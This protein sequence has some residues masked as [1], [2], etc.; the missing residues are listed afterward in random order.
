MN[1]L[2]VGNGGREH[3]IAWKVRQS[4]Q[5]KTVFVAPGNAGT[6]IEPGIQNIDIQPS[7]IDNLIAFAQNEQIDLVIIGPEAALAAGIVDAFDRA[8]IPCFGPTRRAAQLEAS[9]HYA[10]AFLERY[11]IPT[12][13]YRSFTDYGQS[14]DYISTKNFPIVIKA[15]GLAAGKGVVIAQNREE[16]ITALQEMLLQERFGA[17]G[18]RVVIE[19]FLIGEEASFICVVDG[20]QVIPL[21]TSQDHKARDDG[22]QGPNTGGMGAYSPAPLITETCHQRIMQ[23]IIHP[24]LK[25]L[26]NEGTP[27]R[28]FLYA[29]LMIDTDG[30]P[31]VIEYNC[32]LGDPETQPILLRLQ[33]DLVEICQA[34]LNGTLS[35]LKLD[36]DE[37]TAVGVVLAAEGYPS[38]VRKNDVIH[39]LPKHGSP[40][41]AKT[42]ETVKVFHAGTRLN[43]NEEIVTDGGRV[44]CVTALGKDLQ[45]ACDTAYTLTT[46]ITW[47]GRFY[48]TDI[49][50][51]ARR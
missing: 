43:E 40:N 17:S 44:L 37:Q 49:G 29:G 2:I 1:I 38:S 7:D 9:K 5:A 18:H 27:Y 26:V 4:P 33:S 16:A 34:C 23:D 30:N 45:Q 20:E 10:K 8:N 39:G 47:P 14:L 41:T 51:R 25:G 15:D 12:A 42:A 28:G 46:H 13:P 3:A 32:R 6:A 19:D 22:D 31:Y 35:T 36:W 11:H 21:A 50:H 48:R 24:T